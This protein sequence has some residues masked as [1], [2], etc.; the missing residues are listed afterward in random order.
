MGPDIF[1]TEEVVTILKRCK[2]KGGMFRKLLDREEE[3]LLMQS[4]HSGKE[5]WPPNSKVIL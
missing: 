5:R 2:V 4:R 1:A 3:S